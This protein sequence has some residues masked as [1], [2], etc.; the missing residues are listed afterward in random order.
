[1]LANHGGVSRGS[2]S[3]LMVI[4]QYKMAL[5]VNINAN[6]ETFWDFGSVSTELARIFIKVQ[7]QS[8]PK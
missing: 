5:A 8:K 7:Q 1:M 6:T 4:P 3:W 2:Q